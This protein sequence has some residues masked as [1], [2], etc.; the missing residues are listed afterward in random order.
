MIFETFPKK[1]S[2]HFSPAQEVKDGMA[3]LILDLVDL[4][5]ISRPG[6]LIVKAVNAIKESN[7]EMRTNLSDDSYRLARNLNI[8]KEEPASLPREMLDEPEEREASSSSA[9]FR[10][11][12]DVREVQEPPAVE[13]DKDIK[14]AEYLDVG[15]EQ[16]IEEPVADP[17]FREEGTQTGH[18]NWTRKKTQASNQSRDRRKS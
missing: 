5:Y 8:L 1:D 18:S 9:F 17:S 12:A 7:D 6:P 10:E 4:A 13:Q 16:S 3:R 15:T 11:K 2:W 14:I